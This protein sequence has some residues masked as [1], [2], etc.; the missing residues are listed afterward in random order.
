MRDIVNNISKKYL[1]QIEPRGKKSES[2]IN[3]YLVRK[4]ESLLDQATRGRGYK[5][6]H[7]CICGKRSVN[8]NLFI[9]GYIT[10]SLAAHYLR[11]HRNE[12]PRSEI[13]KLKSI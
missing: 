4:M 2:P 13:A 8:Y 7:K 11:W 6:T 5:G 1:L 10:N 3:D 9:R 12:V